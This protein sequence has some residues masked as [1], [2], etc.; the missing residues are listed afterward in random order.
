MAAI[1]AADMSSLVRLEPGQTFA[2]DFE[3][4]RPLAEGGMGA[5]YVARQRSTGHERALKIMHPQLVADPA[6]RAKFE[7]EACVGARIDSDHVVQVVAAGVDEPT[8]TPW[9]AMELLRGE[10]LEQWVK[11]RSPVAA[12]AVKELFEQLRHGMAAAHSRSIVHRDLKPENIFIAE[13]RSPKV[14]FT[15]KVLDFGI[16]RIVR[17]NQTAATV[18]TAIGSP[19]W[20]AP[21]QAS[22]GA[23]IRA[24]T[25]VWALG[26][27]AF[28]VFTG[29]S[30]WLRANDAAGV[31]LQALLVEVM[32]DPI[33]PPSARASALGCPP[34]FPSGFDGWFARCVAR[35]P[36]QRFREAGEC[37]DA[38]L[39]LLTL[40]RTVMMEAVPQP[41]P[42]AEPQ[43]E[44]QPQRTVAMTMPI[45][46]LPPQPPPQ[47]PPPARSS[48][49]D[50]AVPGVLGVLLLIAGGVYFARSRPTE[51]QASADAGVE[52]AQ[53]GAAFVPSGDPPPSDPG[54]YLGE[55][56]VAVYRTPDRPDPRGG[57]FSLAEATAGLSGSGPLRAIIEVPPHGEFQ[58]TLFERAAPNTVANFVGLARGL[59]DFWDPVRGRWT[60]APFYANSIFH[61]VIPNFMIQGGDFLRSGSGGVGYEI[62]DENVSPH[63]RA[64]LLC[65][66]N[67][68]PHTNGGQFFITQGP[69][70]H[71]DGSY[72]IFGEC[73]PTSIVNEI[74][75]VRRDHNDRPVVPVIIRRIT[76]TR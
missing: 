50:M 74:A 31:N 21:E 23:H 37:L 67:H 62:A 72:S 14:P 5:V 36:E 53:A 9:I 22:A 28:Y 12:E 70:A 4:L 68:G 57:S 18:T 63:D 40:Q 43:P 73:T 32:V 24:A 15:L 75:S 34:V 19:L 11:R 33:A 59:R 20:M 58:C 47:P 42:R 44:P 7:Q 10:S 13:S 27:I 66:A 25:D 45:T 1:I 46:A 71:L 51:P 65:M 69:K 48:M 60:R 61:R 26:L 55:P 56:R 17:E 49:A 29:K 16:A 3:V 64:G 6:F 38:L 76:I 35:D 39:K 41:P 2:R 54:A 30:Y 52:V 8:S